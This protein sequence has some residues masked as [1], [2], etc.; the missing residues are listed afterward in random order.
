M[1]QVNEKPVSVFS[2]FQNDEYTIEKFIESLDWSKPWGAGGQFSAL[3]VFAKIN[4]YD[5]HILALSKFADKIVNI[6]NG[7]YYIGSTPS[8][9]EIINGCMKMI[10]GFD[11]INY[12]IH[13][14][15]K[16]IDMCLDI[17]VNNEGCDLVDIVYV[18]YK[19]AEVTDYK[20]LEIESYYLDIFEKIQNHFH[21]SNNGFSYY[22]NKSQTEYYGVKIS[23]GLNVPDIHGNLLLVWALSMILKTIYPDTFDWKILKP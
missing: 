3:C 12:E 22:L 9:T 1:Y 20:K 8:K 4:N 14:P 7:A 15:E 2:E 18:L 10:T 16:L 17:K 13:Y 23:Y 11:W 5:H 19:C 6:Q 21:F